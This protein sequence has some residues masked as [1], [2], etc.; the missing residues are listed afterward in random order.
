MIGEEINTS[1]YLLMLHCNGSHA[2]SGSLSVTMNDVGSG[3]FSVAGKFGNCAAYTYTNG[4]VDITE[5]TGLNITN[6]L[7]AKFWVKT[8]DSTHHTVLSNLYWQTGANISGV[9]VYASGM[10]V[11]P[12][13]SGSG[14]QGAYA[15]T[16]IYD[17]KW[18]F[19]VASYNTTN[20]GKIWV[21]GKLDNVNTS[22]KSAP[23]YKTGQKQAFFAFYDYTGPT[24]Y[25]ANLQVDDFCFG[26][27]A[28]PT[29]TEVRK[30]YAWSTGK[31]I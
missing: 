27:R 10:G 18:H 12:L 5:N 22:F 3:S 1:Q 4:R 14:P 21:D 6:N 8:T 28:E 17:G 15:I 13:N 25:Y 2:N 31:L 29:D 7:F 20:G 26:Q 30:W 23:G 16:N 11:C 9:S 24:W 19:I